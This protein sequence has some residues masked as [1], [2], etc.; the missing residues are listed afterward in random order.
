[1]QLVKR[2]RVARVLLATCVGV[3]WLWFSTLAFVMRPLTAGSF[4]D[5]LKLVGPNRAI[6]GVFGLLLSLGIL[7]GWHILTVRRTAA[8]GTWLFGAWSMGR[9]AK[10]AA[11][12][13]LVGYALTVLPSATLVADDGDSLPTRDDYGVDWATLPWLG[14]LVA[15]S[16]STPCLVIVDAIGGIAR[17]RRR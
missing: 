13:I 6:Q 11:A 8:T 17:A 14:I 4:G 15:A 5:A 10:W 1:M 3:P 16:F 12:S 2:R 7:I 9:I